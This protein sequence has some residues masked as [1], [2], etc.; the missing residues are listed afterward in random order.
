MY[1][2]WL[3]L[4]NTHDENKPSLLSPSS[5]INLTSRHHPSTSSL[6]LV[7]QPNT[8]TS[9]L[10]LM[11]QPHLS[12]SYINLTH[13]PHTSTAMTTNIALCDVF[14]SSP[15]DG[16]VSTLP[17]SEPLRHGNRNCRSSQHT[18]GPRKGRLTHEL[19]RPHWTSA[20]WAEFLSEFTFRTFS[21]R[22]KIYEE[23]AHKTLN[24]LLSLKSWAT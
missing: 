16:F 9:S 6:I 12:S 4:I 11:H 21:L 18:H 14:F 5:P 19:K 15:K 8:S 2:S 13:Q 23:F 20:R 17:S 7:H 10:I 24:R 1:E 3:P 22:M